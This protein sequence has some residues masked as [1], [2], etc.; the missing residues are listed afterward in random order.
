MAN[1][2]L[3]LV[4]HQDMVCR[5]SI[6]AFIKPNAEALPTRRGEGSVVMGWGR[7]CH[8]ILPFSLHRSMPLTVRVMS[9]GEV[10]AVCAPLLPN[11]WQATRHLAGRSQLCFGHCR[12]A[13]CGHYLLNYFS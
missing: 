12:T 6:G 11:M 7:L 8:L 10:L 4:P 13:H 9:K 2:F 3:L 5:H 1:S